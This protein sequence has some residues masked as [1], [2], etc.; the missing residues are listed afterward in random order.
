[1][2]DL[3][4]YYCV[5]NLPGLLRMRGEVGDED[6]AMLLDQFTVMV[7]QRKI[8]RGEDDGWARPTLLG[9][10]FRNDDLTKIKRLTRE[11]VRE[12]P[13]VWQL[14]STL[15]DI[16]DTVDACPDPEAKKQSEEYRDQLASLLN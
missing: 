2:L 5:S 16:S 8:D 13:A 15:Q 10:A 7:T 9:A 1:M 6:E 12:G 14:E 4:E 3:N 11:V